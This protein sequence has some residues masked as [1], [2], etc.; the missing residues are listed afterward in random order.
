MLDHLLH[1]IYKLLQMK[2]GNHLFRKTML[3]S[4]VLFV[5]KFINCIQGSHNLYVPF[6]KLFFV[7]IITLSHHLFPLPEWTRRYLI[8]IISYSYIL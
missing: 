1:Y 8:L 3:L 4:G 6:P 5:N 2:P 7:V